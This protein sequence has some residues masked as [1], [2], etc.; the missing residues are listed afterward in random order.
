[1][2]KYKSKR[3]MLDTTTLLYSYNKIFY[4]SIVIDLIACI[5]QVLH[6]SKHTTVLRHYLK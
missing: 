3:Y 1:M 5:K 2:P 6:C 4:R